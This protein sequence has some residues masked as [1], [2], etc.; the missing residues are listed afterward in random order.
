MSVSPD[1]RQL[2]S[3]ATVAPEAG[4]IIR[5]RSRIAAEGASGSCTLMQPHGTRELHRSVLASAEVFGQSLAKAD[6]L[7]PLNMKSDAK[8]Y[9]LS[10]ELDCMELVMVSLA[11]ER[12]AV[13]LCMTG[14]KYEV[15]MTVI[16]YE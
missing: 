16:V 1:R 15:V 11:E 8:L 3:E 4:G 2:A 14:W 6:E 13:T 10:S 5:T 9:K 7:S 12:A